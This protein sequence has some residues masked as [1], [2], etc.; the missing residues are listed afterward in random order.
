MAGLILDSMGTIKLQVL[1]KAIRGGTLTPA[2][3]AS[4]VTAGAA[5]ESD[6]YAAEF[7]TAIAG[8]G[9]MEPPVREAYVKA[10][11]RIESDHY[12]AE[13]VKTLIAEQPDPDIDPV[14][15]GEA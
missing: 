1:E 13:V 6:H 12:V 5:I 10:I 7:L 8:K 9:R 11:G 4:L 15:S 3:Q 14:C 2:Q